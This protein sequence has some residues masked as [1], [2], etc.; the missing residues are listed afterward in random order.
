MGPESL[1]AS[2]RDLRALGALLRSV[3]L[4]GLC[5]ELWTSHERESAQARALLERQDYI[6]PARFDDTEIPGIRAT[7]G[8][9]DLR[10]TTPAALSQLIL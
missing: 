7:V 4:R 2:R 8:Y 3:R 5:E 6:L 1:H 9:I 10:S